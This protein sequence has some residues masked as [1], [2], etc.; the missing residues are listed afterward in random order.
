MNPVCTFDEISKEILKNCGVDAVAT[1][2]ILI[3]D[4]E[5]GDAKEAIINY[6][7]NFDKKSG[8]YIDFYIPGYYEQFNGKNNEL[9]DRYHPNSYVNFRE[10]EDGKA[11]FEL[12]RNH[13]QYYFSRR[14]FNEFIMEM[15]ERMGIK[16]IY[17]PMLI[18]V[19]VKQEKNRGMLEFQDRLVIDLDRDDKKNIKHTGELF[20][21]IFEV[22]KKTVNLERFCKE[23][24][25]YY[26]K[27]KAVKNIVEALSGEWIKPVA[28][29]AE[30]VYSYRIEHID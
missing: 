15:E 16:Y 10:I 21:K 5:Q 28:S 27:G 20:D 30:D 7:D 17:S 4:W 2:G 23:V 13:T 24:R 22:G 3:A 6:M 19:E 8:K 12:T 11:A 14:L 29:V 26:I 18:L 1:F 9:K 25:L